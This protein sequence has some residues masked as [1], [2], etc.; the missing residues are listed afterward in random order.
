MGSWSYDLAT[1]IGRVRRTIPDRN[2][3]EAIFSDEE[4]ASFV[5]DE[6]D[7]RRG[8]ALALETIAVDEAL[9]QKVQ[10]ISGFQTDGARL[11]TALM[12]R[13][14][15]LRTQAAQADMEDGGAF[16]IA[17]WVT[18]PFSQRERLYNDALRRGG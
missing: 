8:T 13:A 1:D 5:D 6:G 11:A 10:T 18:G 3:T 14:T 16:D 12:A 7:W 17:E 15:A 4:I 9:V 2:Q